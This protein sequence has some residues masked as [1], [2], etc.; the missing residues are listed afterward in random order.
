VDAARDLNAPR[1]YADLNLDDVLTGL[2]DT[3][4]PEAGGLCLRGRVEGLGVYSSPAF[5]ELVVFTPVHRQAM[6]L[7]PYTCTTDAINLQARGIDAGLLVLQP[8]ERW[9]GVVEMVVP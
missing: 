9:T 7:E 2:D 3:A 8:G 5:R 6:C 1:R 4:Q